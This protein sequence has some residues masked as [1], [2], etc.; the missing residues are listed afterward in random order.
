MYSTGT[1]RSRRARTI[2]S[3]SERGTRGSF[4]PG[5]NE[6][7]CDDFVAVAHGAKFLEQW[8]IQFQITELGDKRRANSGVRST[9]ELLEIRNAIKIDASAP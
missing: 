6:Q 7:W 5:V 2:V 9:Q 8:P 3:D 4:C 1:L